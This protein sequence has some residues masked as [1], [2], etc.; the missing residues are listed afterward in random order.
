M[1][2]VGDKTMDI[3]L[4]EFLGFYL[5]DSSEQIERLGAGLLQLEKDGGNIG[6][7]NDLIP[8]GSQFKGSFWNH[9]FHADCGDDPCG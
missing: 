7:I 4:G 9:G 8:L 5:L 2:N 1:S 3:D 6:L